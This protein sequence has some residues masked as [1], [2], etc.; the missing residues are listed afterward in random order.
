MPYGHHIY[1]K[2][3]DMENG[4]MC[5]YP[6]SDN[7]L[8]HY[9]CVLRCCAEFRH[10]NL[11]NQE[12][13]KNIKKTTPSIQFHVYHIIRRCTDHGRIPLKDKKIY[14]MCKKESSSD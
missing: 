2:A 1:A 9:K 3:Y 10:I 5:T 14:Y 13:N 8:T 6:Q 4:T 11:P 12:T 7:A